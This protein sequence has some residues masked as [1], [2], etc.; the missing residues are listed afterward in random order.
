MTAPLLISCAGGDEAGTLTK[1]RSVTLVVQQAVPELTP[2]D[3]DP[4]GPSVGD[5][6]EF[7]A[8][9]SIDG[10]A[11]GELTG[12]LTV[13]KVGSDSGSSVVEE[14]RTGVLTFG[15][16]ETASLTVNGN[17]KYRPGKKEM[18][19]GDPQLRSV[20]GGAGIYE[21]AKGSVTTVHNADGTYTHTFALKLPS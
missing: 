15:L 13:A 9:L 11:V 12:V 5:R 16:G 7:V 18:E 8:A 17:S 1:T 3:N 4:V 21:G 20:T 19:V 14:E 10:R 2:V 6:L